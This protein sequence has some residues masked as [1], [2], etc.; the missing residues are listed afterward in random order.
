MDG[1]TGQ[2]SEEYTLCYAVFSTK[3]E[4]EYESEYQYQYKYSV[5]GRLDTH[6][7][8]LP[9]R[10]RDLSMIRGF[11]RCSSAAGVMLR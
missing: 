2:D 10:D 6:S 4:S 9:K 11:R 7:S 8:S 5:K 1:W 3:Y